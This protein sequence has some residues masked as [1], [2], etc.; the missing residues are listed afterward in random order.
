MDSVG[1]AELRPVSRM[2]WMVLTSVIMNNTPVMQIVI[3]ISLSCELT[4]MVQLLTLNDNLR[5]PK[6]RPEGHN[7]QMNK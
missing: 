3:S 2:Y 1:G 4:N 5:N 7:K 6:N